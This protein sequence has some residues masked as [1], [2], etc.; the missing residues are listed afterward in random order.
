V[1]WTHQIFEADLLAFGNDAGRDTTAT[2]LSWFV[3]LLATNPGIAD[4]IYEEVLILEE[5]EGPEYVN[6]PLSEKMKH[7]SSL[8]SYDVL[9]KLQYLHAALTETMRLYPAVPQVW[10]LLAC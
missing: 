8:L 4:K 3:Y 2:T 1:L 9:F 7:Y 5:D 6:L 10:S